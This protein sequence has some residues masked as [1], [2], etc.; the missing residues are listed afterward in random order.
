MCTDW[1]VLEQ[2]L[3]FLQILLLPVWQGVELNSTHLKKGLQDI[4]IRTW[5]RTWLISLP[6][7]LWQ[8]ST[9]CYFYCFEHFSFLLALLVLKWWVLNGYVWISFWNFLSNQL[10]GLKSNIMMRCG[11]NS[12]TED[13]K[14]AKA[15]PFGAHMMDYMKRHRL[16][17]WGKHLKNGPQKC[18]TLKSW[19]D[20]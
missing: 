10:N 17:L 6:G 16:C 19:S 1:C 13:I 20:R 15:A 9:V 8:I 3:A 4:K 12:Y 5:T 18:P 14:P 2:A 7:S 11:N